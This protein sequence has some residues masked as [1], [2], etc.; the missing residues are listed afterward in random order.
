MMKEIGSN[1]WMSERSLKD[2]LATAT[3]RDLP[4]FEP[5]VDDRVYLSTGRQAIRWVLQDLRDDVKV[6]LLPEFTCYSVMQPF[7][8]EGYEL[9]FY[10]V[11]RSLEVRVSELNRRAIDCGA[12]VC[13]FH[14]YFGFPT[15]IADEAF[16][17]DVV[18]IYDATQSFFSE[19]S[20]Y[21][22][23]YI[24]ASLRKW[25]ALLDGGFAGK[26]QGVFSNDRALPTDDAMVSVMCRAF[27]EKARY[28]TTGDGDK[29][30][31]RADYARAL[32]ML[33]ARDAVFSMA[34]ASL[35]VY[36]QMDIETL[37]TRRQRHFDRL[38]AIDWIHVGCPV[39]DRRPIG[40]VPLYFPLYVEETERSAFQAYLA[41][42]AIY[43][44]II[45]SKPEAYRG[46][47]LDPSVERIYEC[48]LSIPIDQ[49]YDDKDLE[50]MADVIQRY[51]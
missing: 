32:S 22:V 6:A 45:W 21:H 17:P 13:L 9:H 19:M 1:F 11:N 48:I 41:H 26:V 18:V 46:R 37:R 28:M 8:Q 49:R 42:H 12:T 27:D 36:R 31:F 14:P 51:A 40:G 33:R 35:A 43:A 50:R 29:A 30:T 5:D 7:V 15:V 24:V 10:P 23:D 39:F 20:L 3:D 34:P 4:A 47:E 44:P 38:L 16:C 25:G 2:A